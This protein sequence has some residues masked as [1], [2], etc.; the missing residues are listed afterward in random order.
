MRKHLQERHLGFP[1]SV[2]FHHYMPLYQWSRTADSIVQF[3]VLIAAAVGN[4]DSDLP[5]ALCFLL[6]LLQALC[7]FAG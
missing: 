6:D 4:L 1:A 5:Q 2:L 3:T 7:F